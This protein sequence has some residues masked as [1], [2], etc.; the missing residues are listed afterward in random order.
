MNFRKEIAELFRQWNKSDLLLD[1]C[2]SWNRELYKQWTSTL[3]DLGAAMALEDENM[4]EEAKAR[5][6]ETFAI[7]GQNNL[8][9]KLNQIRQKEKEHRQQQG[10]IHDLT[11]DIKAR[12]LKLQPH[13]DYIEQERKKIEVMKERLKNYIKEEGK[14][15]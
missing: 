14:D 15:E 5:Y 7:F 12:E 10:L 9:L 1:Q 6:I 4:F 11:F 3:H 8:N 13:V 2:A